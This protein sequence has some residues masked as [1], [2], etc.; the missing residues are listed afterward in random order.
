MHIVTPTETV[1]A[2]QTIVTLRTALATMELATRRAHIQPATVLDVD[3]VALLITTASTALRTHIDLLMDS[4]P[5]MSVGDAQTRELLAATIPASVTI[6]VP[7][8]VTDQPMTTVRSVSP[9]PKA[10]HVNVRPDTADRLVSTSISNAT[11]HVTDAQDLTLTSAQSVSKTPSVTPVVNVFAR[12]SGKKST[13]AI[14]APT[15]ST[16]TQCAWMMTTATTIAVLVL[17][18]EEDSVRHVA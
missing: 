17:D 10:L 14:P 1:S 5:V 9:T 15:S 2:T 16:A 18:Q 11:Q 7:A 6:G 12:P 8:D 13:I 4:V 3:V